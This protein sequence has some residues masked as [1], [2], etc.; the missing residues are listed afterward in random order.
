MIVVRG[1]NGITAFVAG[2]RLGT[3]A[4][5]VLCLNDGQVFSI[6]PGSVVNLRADLLA[7]FT[8]AVQLNGAVQQ[9]AELDLDP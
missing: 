2:P 9:V 1:A 8:H 4:R 3:V 7:I 5:K 6:R